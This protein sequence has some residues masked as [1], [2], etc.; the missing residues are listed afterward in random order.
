MLLK[1]LLT[2]LD[3]LA[4]IGALCENIETGV[5]VFDEVGRYILVN[6]AYCGI[7]GYQPEDLLGQAFTITLPPT[8]RELGMQI[9][10]DVLE[11]SLYPPAEWL[12]RRKDGTNVAVQATNSLLQQDGGGR[13]RV[14][15]I[16]DISARKRLE[17]ELEDLREQLELATST[18]GLTQVHSRSALLQAAEH[19]LL[20]AQR[21]GHPLSVVLFDLDH[22]RRINDT[23]GPS[24]GDEVLRLVATM[25]RRMI[26]ITDTI[27]RYGGEEFAVILP[28][29][30]HAGGLRMA[31]RMRKALTSAPWATTAGPVMTSASF[32]VGTNEPEDV[33]CDMMLMRA[34][35][36]LYLAKQRGRNRVVGAGSLARRG[37]L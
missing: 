14:V 17:Q 37:A 18:D 33:S 5:C 25:A 35:A 16:E 30:D 36:A 7:H 6:K 3:P 29:T 24:V 27:G 22:F 21:Y 2:D 9:H 8:V 4:L 19:E 15:V 32:G 13:F 1:E 31:R 10:R 12:V 11:G 26:R 20:R 34:S 23:H 28:V